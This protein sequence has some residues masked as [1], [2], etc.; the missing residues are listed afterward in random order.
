MNQLPATINVAV[1]ALVLISI[2]LVIGWRN[3]GDGD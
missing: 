2:A 3:L 1:V